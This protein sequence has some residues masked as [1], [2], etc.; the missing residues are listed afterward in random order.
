MT[1]RHLFKEKK[2]QE[3]VMACQ[4]ERRALRDYAI[5]S[6]IRATSCTKKPTI[7]AYNFKLKTELIRMVQNNYQF[8]GLPNDD[9]YEHIANFLEICDTQQ[10]GVP[11]EKVRL[12]FFPFSLRD[13]AKIWFKSLPKEL[14]TT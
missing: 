3:A 14:I 8:G 6:L 13:K 5:P 4:E 10:C 1:L 9:P 12:M 11:A 2:N 7:Q